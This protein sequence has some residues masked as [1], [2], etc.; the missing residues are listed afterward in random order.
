MSQAGAWTGLQIL[1]CG[2]AQ[3]FN[4]S[5]LATGPFAHLGLCQPTQTDEP[6]PQPGMATAGREQ[7]RGGNWARGRTPKRKGGH[8]QAGGR[9]RGKQTAQT[10]NPNLAR[11]TGE[12]NKP[13]RPMRNAGGGD[14][15]GHAH[16][17]ARANK[18]THA[19]REERREER[20]G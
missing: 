5:S 11:A 9:A 3:G 7:T 12:P 4:S 13:N 20:K 16:A 8:G 1:G 2:D 15:G 19:Q 10:L 17:R 14:E 18:R 6:A